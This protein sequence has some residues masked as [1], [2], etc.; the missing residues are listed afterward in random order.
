MNQICAP[1]QTRQPLLALHGFTGSGADFQWL[2]AQT[3]DL[4]N[5]YTLDLPGHGRNLPLPAPKKTDGAPTNADAARPPQADATSQTRLP[6]PYTAAATARTIDAALTSIIP[7]SQPTNAN[8]SLPANTT[9]HLPASASPE[10]PTNL[11]ASACSNLPTNASSHLPTNTSPTPA[12][13]ANTTV[14]APA[15]A[16]THSPANA[17]VRVNTTSPANAS[18]PKHPTSPS[19]PLLLGYSMGGRMAL[20]YLAHYGTAK[21]SG[22]VLIGASAGIADPTQRRERRRA[23]HALADQIEAEGIDAF[24]HYWNDVPLIASQRNSPFY[25]QLQALRHRNRADGLAASLRGIGTGALCPLHNRLAA[26]RIPCLLLTGAQ[27]KKFTALAHELAHAL[28]AAQHVTIAQA[29][30][31]PHWEAPQATVD[32]IRHWLQVHFH[33]EQ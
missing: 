14:G 33:R 9:S 19:L 13:P 16:A 1:H 24:M 12:L 17:A 25:E 11:S 28:P 22:L 6:L 27:D 18:L 32:A 30:H 21:V 7:P 20:R 15:P 2:A 4:L 10:L 8:S 26:I 3:A 31:A 23:D 5:W 29:G